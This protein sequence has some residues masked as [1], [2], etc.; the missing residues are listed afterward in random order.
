LRFYGR[1]RGIPDAKLQKMVD[2]LIKRLSLGKYAKRPAGTYSGGN[3][4]KL[5]V[6]IALIGN[7]PIVFLDEP[8]TGMD[9]VSRRF[10]WD[11]ISETMAERAV[12]LTTHRFVSPFGSFLPCEARCAFLSCDSMEECEAL[13]SRIGILVAGSLKCIG[14]SQH[15]KHRFGRGFQLD[16]ST[17]ANDP[18]PAQEVA[19][20]CFGFFSS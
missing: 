3:K 1:I 19:A 7:P 15:L 13:C 16:I 20:L 2:F 6:A 5:S 8:S 17:G 11:F 4:R 18:A 12:I 14:S 9:P 10:M